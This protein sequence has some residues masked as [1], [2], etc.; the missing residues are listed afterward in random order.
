M[1]DSGRIADEY[2]HSL[3][4]EVKTKLREFAEIAFLQQEQINR[5]IKRIE[6]LEQANNSD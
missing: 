3:V 2:K 1:D 6:L 5:L 4:I